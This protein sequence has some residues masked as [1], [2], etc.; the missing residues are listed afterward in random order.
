MLENIDGM[1]IDN[2][3]ILEELFCLLYVFFF[4]YNIVS[5]KFYFIYLT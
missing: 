1:T 3:T 5:S 2:K 4:F